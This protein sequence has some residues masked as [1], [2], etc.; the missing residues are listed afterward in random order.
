ME[1]IYTLNIYINIKGKGSE[2]YIKIE[3][4]RIRY[5]REVWNFTDLLQRHLKRSYATLQPERVEWQIKS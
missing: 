3:W 5:V 4:L 1:N 2:D